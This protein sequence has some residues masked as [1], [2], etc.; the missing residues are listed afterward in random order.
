MTDTADAH[1][2]LL[3]ELVHAERALGE[4]NP[5]RSRWLPPLR[6]GGVSLQVCAIYVEHGPSSWA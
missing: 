1:S 6:R 4:T 3:M 5:F 2:D